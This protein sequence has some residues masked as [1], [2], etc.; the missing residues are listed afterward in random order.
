MRKMKKTK[1]V[2]NWDKGSGYYCFYFRNGFQLPR[3]YLLEGDQDDEEE[4]DDDE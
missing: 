1:K 4:E 2:S 3:C